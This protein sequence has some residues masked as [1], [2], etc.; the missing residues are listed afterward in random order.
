MLGRIKGKSVDVCERACA[1]LP[2][3]WLFENKG[4]FTPGVGYTAYFAKPKWVCGT[5]HLRGC[6]TTCACLDCHRAI[7]PCHP[8]DKCRDC[9][10]T[11]LERRSAEGQE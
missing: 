1:K 9:G 8:Q 11:N 2:C 4:S 3:L 7:A 6:P 5:R 10:S